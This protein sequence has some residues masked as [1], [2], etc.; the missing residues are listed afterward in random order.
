MCIYIQMHIVGFLTF[1][2]NN[3]K[4]SIL[5]V[6]IFS[7]LFVSC[8]FDT[9]GQYVYQPPDNINDGIDVGSLDEVNIDAKWIERAVDE[10]Q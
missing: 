6:S 5:V 1:K 8:Q 10:I 9:S 7:L 4:K 3:M 2:L